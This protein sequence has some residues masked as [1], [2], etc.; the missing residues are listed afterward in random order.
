MRNHPPLKNTYEEDQEFR[1]TPPSRRPP[2][3]RYQNYFP[4][5]CYSCSNFGHKVV[6]CRAYVRFE[7]SWNRNAY[8]NPRNQNEGNYFRKP[9]EAFNRNYNSFGV[10]N[11]EVE[12]YKCNNFGHIARNCRSNMIAPSRE[13]KHTPKEQQGIW[14]R[15]QG[16]FKVEECG[17]ALQAQSRNSQWYIDSGCSKHMTGDKHRFVKLKKEKE[18]SITFGNN[19][20][21]KIIGKDTINL[22]SNDLVAENVLLVENMKHNLLSVSQMCD[23]G[24]TLTFDSEQCEI[25]KKKSGKLVATTT[26]TANNIYILDDIGKESC[27]LGKEEEIWLWHRR[28]GHLHFENLVKINKKQAVREMPKIT[29]PKNILCKHC[30]HGKQTKV[31][32]KSKEYSTT[33]PLELVHTDLCGPMRT[34]GL[35]GEQYLMVLVD[36][37]TRMTWICLLKKKSEAFESF[38]IFKELVENETDMKIKCLRSDNGG[39]FTSNEFMDY[40]E[41][42]GIKR[43]FST[44]RTPQQNGVTERKNMTIQEMART[45]LKESKLGDIFWGQ[46]VHTTI[47]IL[48]RGLLRSNSDK[49]PYELWK[50]RPTNVKHFRVF[51]SKCYIKRE[52]GIGKFDSRV[53]KGILVGYSSMRKA[54]KCYN[55][56]LN[57]IV[58]SIN[59]KVDEASLQKLK[60]ESRNQDIEDESDIEE[61]KIE[62]DDGEEFEVQSEKRQPETKEKE[63]DQKNL[64]TPSRTPSKTSTSHIL[65]N[66]PPEQIIGDK[67]AG[68]ETRKRK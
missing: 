26:R 15:K 24:H 47:H 33:K 22:G 12:C 23:Q 54:Y 57:K 18:G 52:D 21:T 60:K 16:E 4:G 25:R 19:N 30:Q 41:E 36:D 34:K 49:T 67:S 56:R 32:F 39:E 51:G 44:A 53:D 59:V 8:G 66:H 14:K 1:R 58:E 65:K 42:H 45:M 20:S 48:N 2:T 6:D 68:V 3:F 13:I 61:L 64:R 5:L 37:Y 40:C 28:M 38:R 11:F 27:C 9:R 31:E 10:L 46:A 29:K 55:L 50:G 63:D 7:S 35:D 62:E 43:Q 17:L